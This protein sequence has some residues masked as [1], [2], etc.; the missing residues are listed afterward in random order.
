MKFL[1]FA[2]GICSLFI[3]IY[4]SLKHSPEGLAILF[5][6]LFAGGALCSS[7]FDRFRNKSGNSLQG[8][9]DDYQTI[10][11]NA[12]DLYASSESLRKVVSEENTAVSQSSSAIEEISAM[13]SRTAQSASDLAVMANNA[14][15]AV[16]EGESGISELLKALG[17]IHKSTDQLSSGLENK[18]NELN[19]VTDT[20]SQ[21]KVKAGLIDTI[22]FQTKLLSFNASVEAARAGESGKGFAVVAQEM[23]TLAASSGSASK[24]IGDILEQSLQSTAMIVTSMKDEL[25]RLM[26][27]SKSD[28]KTGMHNSQ[29]G[30]SAFSKIVTEV[31]SVAKLSAEIS[32]ATEQQDIGVKEVTKAI[33]TLQSTSDQLNQVAEKTLKTALNLSEKS[34][35]QQKQLVAISNQLGKKL[36]TKDKP[37]DFGA[38]ISAHLD[39]KMKLSRYLETPDGSLDPSKVCLDNACALGKWLYG[40]GQKHRSHHD[41]ENLRLAHSDFHK[42][43]SEIITLINKRQ[44][45]QAEKL[46]APSGKYV[47]TSEKCVGLIELLRD[48]LENR[49]YKVA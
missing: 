46:L 40:D 12:R 41:F 6:G 43:A 26:E 17:D 15:S 16:N 36:E 25:T 24:E 27:K 18:L 42:T 45:H 23:G 37:F 14:K 5:T 21:I 4:L 44:I 8:F 31:D 47:R 29:K 35:S 19:R 48:E 49:E 20:L 38:A 28:V 11:E 2:F 3:S 22:V 33:H 32:S 1:K 30:Q 13:L 9:A 7:F 34:E 10:I 39:W